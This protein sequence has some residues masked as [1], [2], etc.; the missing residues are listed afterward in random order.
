[1]NHLTYQDLGIPESY[2][3]VSFHYAATDNVGIAIFYRKETPNVRRIFWKR[4]DERKY[5]MISVA[6]ENHSLDSCIPTVSSEKIYYNLMHL[7][8]PKGHEHFGGYWSSLNY[9]CLRT[10]TD[11]VVI[12]PADLEN[13]LGSKNPWISQIVHISPDESEIDVIAGSELQETEQ[14]SE[15][16]YA[17][18][19]IALKTGK[20][21][22]RFS[23]PGVFI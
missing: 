17:V 13:M 16:E 14:I 4:A 2:V 18:Y 6:D 15:M 19:R 12:S 23:L 1:M 21:T 8:K 3:F 5:S 22:R 20:I 11:K 9:F 10:Q 7:K